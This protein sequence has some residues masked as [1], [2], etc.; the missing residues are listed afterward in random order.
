MIIVIAG[1]HESLREQTQFRINEGFIG[2]DTS[3]ILSVGVQKRGVGKLFDREG[4][5]NQ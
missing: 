4:A 5:E 1:I 3:D 2:L